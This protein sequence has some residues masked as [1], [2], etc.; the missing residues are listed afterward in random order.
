MCKLIVR[1]EDYGYPL[2]TSPTMPKRSYRSATSLAK[3]STELA[4]AT[5]QVMAHRLTRMAL[6]GPVLSARDRH[7]F[8]RM[9]AEKTTAFTESWQ[10]MGWHA[11]QNQQ[12]WWKAMMPLL[13]APSPH[14][15]WPTTAAAAR[16]QNEALAMLNQGLAPVHRTAV[17]NAKRLQRTKL[18]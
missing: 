1:V 2:P 11:W 16:L 7:E 4:I 5:P 6:A 10:A 3:R 14:A 8:Q 17:A 12:R 18:R 15:W 13:S 9:H